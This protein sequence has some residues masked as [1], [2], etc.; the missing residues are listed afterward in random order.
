MFER[1]ASAW[2]GSAMVLDI[3]R[4]AFNVL[5]TTFCCTSLNAT[6][7]AASGVAGAMEDAGDVNVSSPAPN[8]DNEEATEDE[9]EV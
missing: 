2:N 9:G 5:P 6:A 1:S 7:R 3:R 4:T 8:Q